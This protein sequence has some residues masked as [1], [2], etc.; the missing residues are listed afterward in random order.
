[1]VPNGWMKSRLGSVAELQRGFDLPSS[2]RI[3]GSIPI[4]SSGGI[5]GYHSES[6]CTT[7]M[8]YLIILNDI[9]NHS[10]VISRLV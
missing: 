10:R 1:M 2:Q 4:V 3:E 5:T 7:K 6:K 8:I 9:F